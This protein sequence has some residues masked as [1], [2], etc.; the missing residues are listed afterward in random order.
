MRG[1]VVI[2]TGAAGAL[3]KS[4]AAEFTSRGATVAAV[5]VVAMPGS[6]SSYPCDL[7]DA[8]ACA[9]IVARIRAAH[10]RID[11]L[12]NVAGG[13]TMGESVYETSDATFESM[14]DINARTLLNITRAVVPVLLER[15][16][17]GAIV[18]VAARAGLR[19][20]AGMGAYAASKSVVIRLTEALADELKSKGINVNC[21]MPSIIDTPRNRADMPDADY[22]RWVK[23]ASLA[24]VIAFLA[25]PD[26]RDIHGAAIPVEGLS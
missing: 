18:N 21:V 11:A 5:D 26:A 4:V 25:S 10:G 16:N 17:G 23:P 8:A 20:S 1:S 15:G 6:A 3:G 13:F 7:M 14:L 19:G 22:S 9:D 12:I 2:V 24:K